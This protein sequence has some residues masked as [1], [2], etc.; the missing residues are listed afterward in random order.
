M[1]WCAIFRCIELLPLTD[2]CTQQSYSVSVHFGDMMQKCFD[3]DFER[4]ISSLLSSEWISQYLLR[5]YLLHVR[6]VLPVIDLDVSE[7]CQ[8][9]LES[10]AGITGRVPVILCIGLSGA[11]NKESGQM[12]NG[13]GKT[14]RGEASEATSTSAF[15]PPHS[16][17][18]FV[19]IAWSILT[20]NTPHLSGYLCLPT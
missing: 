16:T 5:F 8:A 12:T 11:E 3:D 17:V 2:N 10:V 19:F 6:G 13:G 18:R 9:V 1:T 4:V 20:N 7:R 15:S 14:G